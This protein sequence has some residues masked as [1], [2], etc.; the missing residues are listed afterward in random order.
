LTI[1]AGAGAGAGDA[2]TKVT[3]ERTIATET[4]IN[5]MIEREFSI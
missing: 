2:A 5:F 3:S 1:S 4:E